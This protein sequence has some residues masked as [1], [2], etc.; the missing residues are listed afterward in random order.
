MTHYE[1]E[2]LPAKEKESLLT[3]IDH[4]IKASKLS[5]L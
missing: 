3:T 2:M 4:F 5:L 1:K